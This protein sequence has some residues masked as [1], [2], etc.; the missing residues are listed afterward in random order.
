MLSCPCRSSGPLQDDGC[1]VASD[2]KVG[3]EGGFDVGCLARLVHDVVEVGAAFR[4]LREISH[5]WDLPLLDGQGAD[6]GLHGAAGTKGVAQGRFRGRD[7]DVGVDLGH[8]L[9]LGAVTGHSTGAVGVYVTDLL[10]S[11]SGV[12]DGKLHGPHDAQAFRIWVGQVVR[13]GGAADAGNLRVRVG[14]AA[15]Y[16][17]G[18]LQHH[19]GRRLADQEPRVVDVEGPARPFGIIVTAAHRPHGY[20]SGDNDGRQA[21]LRSAAEHD[22]GVTTPDQVVAQPHHVRAAGAG[23]RAGDRRSLDAE[24]YAYVGR[25][26]VGHDLGNSE[27]VYAGGSLTIYGRLGRLHAGNAPDTAAEDEADPLGVV[28]EHIPGA[29]VF[30]GQLGRGEAHLPEPVCPGRHFA[31]HKALGVE[32]RA[33]GG[34]AHLEV[35]GIEERYGAGPALVG[36]E[37]APEL[38]APYSYGGDRT[39]PRYVSLWAPVCHLAP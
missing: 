10:S 20:E 23:E 9:R 34:D 1:V 21:S 3:A 19:H 18:A 33:L 5:R 6:R 11:Q 29:R 8:R 28:V 2:A 16:G 31:V 37:R 14:P 15:P 12:G 24:L 36:Q 25:G 4:Y 22:V 30:E 32:V 17:L 39:D 38:L 27:G 35:L 13:I 26:G 7:F